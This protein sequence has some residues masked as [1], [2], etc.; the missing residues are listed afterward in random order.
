M[1]TNTFGI[2]IG[3]VDH[4]PA[5]AYHASG[6]FKDVESKEAILRDALMR[7]G[8]ELGSVDETIVRWLSEAEWATFAT[9]TSWLVR[10][11]DHS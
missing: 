9:V 4:E 7:N 8:V 3:P 11:T 6:E 10:T 1:D 2:P 5:E